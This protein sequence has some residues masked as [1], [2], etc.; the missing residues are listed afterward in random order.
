LW[1]GLVGENVLYPAGR[2][3][4]DLSKKRGV[5]L[6]QWRESRMQALEQQLAKQG[7]G[8]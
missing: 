7:G 4:K 3:G 6:K 5:L 1:Q 8:K 2:D